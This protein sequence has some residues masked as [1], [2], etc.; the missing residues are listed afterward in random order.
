MPKS[1]EVSLYLTIIKY[2]NVVDTEDES[3]FRYFR[4]RAKYT[5]EKESTKCDFIPTSIY[6]VMELSKDIF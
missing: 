5:E 2:I 6:I 1:G 4:H 3:S